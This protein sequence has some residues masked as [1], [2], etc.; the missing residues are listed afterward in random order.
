LTAIP[1]QPIYSV[2]AAAS[3]AIPLTIV[4]GSLW[5]IL[6]EIVWASGVDAADRAVSAASAIARTT[7]AAVAS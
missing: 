2:A 7:R 1:R 6:S 5:G 3:A 4:P